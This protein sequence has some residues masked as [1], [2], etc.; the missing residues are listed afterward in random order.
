MSHPPPI[1]AHYS[2][3]PS[4]LP[5]RT[6]AAPCSVEAPCEAEAQCAALAKADKVYAAASEDMD[7]MTFG[8]PRLVRCASAGGPVA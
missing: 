5:L 8:T 1:P 2:R 7:T 3:P 6:P 4:V